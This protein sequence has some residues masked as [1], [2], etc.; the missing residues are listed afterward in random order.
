MEFGAQLRRGPRPR[1]PEPDPPD[2]RASM[3]ASSPAVSSSSQGNGQLARNRK[4]STAPAALKFT[5]LPKANSELIRLTLQLADAGWRVRRL[6]SRLAESLA[7][8]QAESARR[9]AAEARCQGL[10]LE[11]RTRQREVSSLREELRV[12][13]EREARGCDGLREQ[14]AAQAEQLL[15]LQRARGDFLVQM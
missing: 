6:T 11:I 4:G 5:S 9:E 13:V 15:Q 8:E 12:A 1:T 10:E 2:P 14:G 3:R 7:T